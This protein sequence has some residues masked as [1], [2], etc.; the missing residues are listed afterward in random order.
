MSADHEPVSSLTHS[1][2]SALPPG[3][4]IQS[5]ASVSMSVAKGL[6]AVMDGVHHDLG[7]CVNDDQTAVGRGRSMERTVE[8]AED[9]FEA[10]Q[11]LAAEQGWGDGLPLVTPTQARVDA[12][13]GGRDPNH[14]LG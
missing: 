14:V 2:L 4:S 8:I 13:L 1:G 9:S 5:R 11:R 3:V 6:S 12:M 7:F 10:M